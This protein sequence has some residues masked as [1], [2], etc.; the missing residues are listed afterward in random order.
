[1]KVPRT[2]G[3]P[4]ALADV[5][6]AVFGAAWGTDGRIL[7]STAGQALHVVAEDGGA[8]TDIT[9]HWDAD[10]ATSPALGNRWAVRWPT[11]LPDGRHALVGTD[12]LISVVDLRTGAMRP[13]IRGAQAQ[14][15]AIGQLLFHEDE[16]RMRVVPF[17]VSRMA[18]TGAPVPAFEAFRGPGSG[19]AQFAVSRAGTLIY[20][21]GGFDRTMVLVDRNGRES[22]MAVPPRGYRFPRFAPAGDRVAVTVDPRPSRIW[23]VDIRHNTSVPITKDVHNIQ[24]IWRPD[25]GAIVFRNRDGAT[26]LRLADG[27]QVVHRYRI[28][29]LQKGTVIGHPFATDWSTTRGILYQVVSG[30]DKWIATARDDSTLVPL[31][32]STGSDG[33]ASLSPDQHWVALRSTVS[34]VPQ[35]YV[36]PFPGAGELRLVSSNGGV[37]PRWSADGRELFYRESNRIMHVSIRTVPTYETLG[38]PQELFAGTFDFSQENNWDVGRDGRFLMIRGDARTRAGFLLVTNWFDELRAKAPH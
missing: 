32:G 27:T 7:F 28:L 11:L 16:G 34:G 36:R 8:V 6:G 38:L 21:A 9:L 33:E 4:I 3:A 29:Q 18:I 15:L 17:D 14:Y 13:L 35:V 22:A 1:M 20:V 30:S 31:P 25:G 19:S 10:A 12:T 26:E 24:P 5:R 23:L 37:E 2:G